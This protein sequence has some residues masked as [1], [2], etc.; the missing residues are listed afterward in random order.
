[1]DSDRSKIKRD[2]E[3]ADD[4][5][6]YYRLEDASAPTAGLALYFNHPD[7]GWRPVLGQVADI[8]IDHIVFALGD[9]DT[10]AF[11][12]LFE[13][14]YSE[15]ADIIVDRV[16]A[17]TELDLSHEEADIRP[18]DDIVQG[19]PQSTPGQSHL[20]DYRSQR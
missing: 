6:E 7:L 9:T 3:N 15:Y 10:G 14:F 5:A 4:T 17:R 2:T 8:E 20:H 18:A 13:T 12:T 16:T 19:L 11:D 1:M